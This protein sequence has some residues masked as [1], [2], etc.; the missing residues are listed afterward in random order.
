MERLDIPGYDEVVR[1]P[2]GSS[3]AFVAIHALVGGRAFGGIRIRDYDDEQAALDDALRLAHAMSR[4]VA[5]HGLPAGGAKTVLVR[6]KRDRAGALEALGAYIESLGG[7]YHC[8][9][10]YGFGPQDDAALRRTTQHL[11]ATEGLGAATA[12][13]VHSAITAIC[14]PRAVALQG[15]GAV[16]LPLARL[17]LADGVRVVASDIRAVPGFEVVPPSSIYDIDCDVFAPCAQGGVLDEQT[18]ERL[19]CRIVCGAANNPLVADADAERLRERGILYVPDFVANAGAVIVGGSIAAGEGS[20]AEE[21]LEAIGPRVLE[22]LERA[23]EE[24]RSPHAV[25]VDEADRLLA[26]ARDR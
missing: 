23:D 5:F 17:L 16:G 26:A 25:A 19:H 15:L 12:R 10:D 7:R 11:A 6:P 21:R 4:K 14:M 13:G 20:R 18:I 1:V 8:G 2:C 22:V 24:G 9:P 3:V